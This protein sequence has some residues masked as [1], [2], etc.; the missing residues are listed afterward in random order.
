MSYK[1]YIQYKEALKPKLCFKK[2]NDNLEDLSDE[3]LLKD[4]NE[5]LREDLYS[6]LKNNFYPFS[7][8][9]RIIVNSKN[10]EKI[11]NCIKEIKF[12][13]K[14]KEE[15]EKN[16]LIKESIKKYKLNQENKKEISL[17]ERKEIIKKQKKLCE[18]KIENLSSQLIESLKKI[19]CK[20]HS[21]K[22]EPKAIKNTSKLEEAIITINEEE[23]LLI[24]LNSSY[25]K[26][27]KDSKKIF[28]F[29]KSKIESVNQKEKI[30][31]FFFPKRNITNKNFES[32]KKDV[33]MGIK[34]CLN[35]GFCLKEK[36]SSDEEY[37]EV[38]IDANKTQKKDDL[39]IIK[40]EANIF[41][42]NDYEN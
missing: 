16:E 19:K 33:S 35:E 8:E 18:E 7:D 21:V 14:D 36:P 32:F 2:Y 3:V 12:W 5:F 24:N 38:K 42:I 15:E 6:K 4:Y 31:K 22:I 13:L 34:C 20:N 40:E 1:K 17:Q 39:Y 11:K 10:K 9:F 25:C 27:I 26:K 41:W 28:E 29:L 30:K 23:T 37:V